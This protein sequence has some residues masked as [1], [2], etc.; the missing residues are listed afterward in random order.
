MR[1]TSFYCAKNGEDETSDFLRRLTNVDGAIGETV[2]TVVT[3][4]I[5]GKGTERRDR[6]ATT[7]VRQVHQC[8]VASG[9]PLGKSRQFR[10]WFLTTKIMSNKKNLG[11]VFV[12][13][14]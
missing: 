2:R 7:G 5:L 3:E 4:W 13:I 8:N 10:V 9:V 6:V 12:D 14:S 1:R 11:N